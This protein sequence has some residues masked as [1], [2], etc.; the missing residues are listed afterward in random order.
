M[1]VLHFI[2]VWYWGTSWVSKDT[3]DNFNL[4]FGHRRGS[5]WSRCLSL[6]FGAPDVTQICILVQIVKKK[7]SGSK[8]VQVRQ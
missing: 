5:A 1:E 7:K 3:C 2:N 4:R 8:S 6:K